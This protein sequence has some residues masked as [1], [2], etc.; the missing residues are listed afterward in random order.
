[1][2]CEFDLYGRDSLKNML[3]RQEIK[4]GVC[5]KKSRPKSHSRKKVRAFFKKKL[6]P[7]KMWISFVK[8]FPAKCHFHLAGIRVAGQGYIAPVACS[9][10]KSAHN[11]TR[12][13][14]RCDI[15]EFYIFIAFAWFFTTN[16]LSF[17][18]VP[19]DQTL[20]L[21]LFS[22]WSQTCFPKNGLFSD[23]NNLKR[24]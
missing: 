8:D 16:F 18:N 22:E 4:W 23:K 13:A 5:E 6:V 3:N 24:L 10:A 19:G 7:P 17:L 15:R 2:L 20:F 11:R 14:L 9:V 12:L 21:V 1:M